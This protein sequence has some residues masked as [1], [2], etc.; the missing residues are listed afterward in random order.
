MNHQSPEEVLRSD[1]TPLL[2]SKLQESCKMYMITY[3]VTNFVDISL[4]N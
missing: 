2:Y 4:E 1:V 3:I